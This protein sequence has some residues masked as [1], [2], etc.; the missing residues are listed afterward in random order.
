MT[1]GNENTQTSV[2]TAGFRIVTEV[3]AGLKTMCALKSAVCY[4]A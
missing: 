3:F 1:G 4:S 2:R